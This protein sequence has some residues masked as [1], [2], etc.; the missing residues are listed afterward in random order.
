MTRGVKWTLSIA[1]AL[2]AVDAA[3]LAIILTR[4][5]SSP[6]VVAAAGSRAALPDTGAIGGPFTLVTTDGKVVTDQTYRGKWMLIFFGYTNCGD[7]CRL[8]LTNVSIA[9]R[10]LGAGGEAIETLYV[11]VDPDRDAPK[12]I[13][14]YLKW[15]NPRIVGLRGNSQQTEAVK[16]AYRI[17]VQ[18]HDADANG[19]AE[20]GLGGVIYL[21][22]PSGRVVSGVEGTT[23]GDL[24]A[25]RLRQLM[26]EGRICEPGAER[27]AGGLCPATTRVRKS[28]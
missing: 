28:G 18:L 12:V 24:M 13:A 16:E 1:L 27:L 3:I 9:I 25:S 7:P 20:S 2:L 14:E 23:P 11:T 22:D 5:G 10:K 21:T 6:S 8:A 17:R 19:H 15:F 26:D 4:A